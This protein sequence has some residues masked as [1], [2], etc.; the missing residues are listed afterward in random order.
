MKRAGIFLLFISL[1]TVAFGQKPLTSREIDS[2][3]LQTLKTFDVPGIAVAI[4]KDGKVTHEKGYGVRSIKT[5]EPVNEHTLFGIASN[6]K[7]FT[8][9]AL[10]MLVD[11]G[12]LQWTDRVIDFIPGFK[13]YNPYVTMNFTIADLLTHRSGLGLGA[14]DLMIWP[15]SNSFTKTEI[16]HNMRFLKPVS[17]FRTKYDYDNLLYLVAG[18][19][20]AKISGISWEEFIE[21]RIMKPLQMNESAASINR[22][23]NKT[24]VI[25]PHAPVDG[26]LKVLD[27]NWSETA[28]AAGGIYSSVHDMS[29]WVLMQLNHGNLDNGKHLFSEERQKEMWSPHTIIPVSAKNTYHTHFA[30]YG[31]GWRLNDEMGFKTVSHTGGLAG[32]VTQVMLVP[33]LDLGII[34]FTNQQSGAAFTALTNAIKDAYYGLPRT[35]R[36]KEYHDRVME[37]SSHAKNITDKVWQQVEQAEKSKLPGIDLKEYVGTY[38]DPWF[39]DIVI[40]KRGDHLYFASKKSPRLRGT[41]YFYKGNTFV[42]KWEDR[43]MDAD[44]FVLFRQNFEGQPVGIRMKPISPATDFSFDFQ[45]LD[46]ERKK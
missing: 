16:I 27:I 8:A 43:A 40:D 30:A 6:S 31:F 46:F 39:G 24:N 20:V 37:A 15:D 13:L 25:D 41:M 9:A 17:D 26:K 23:E 36:I 18:E 34:V 11:E 7:A 14:G 5:M 3:A 32:I 38:I 28:N 33:E 35:D 19:V 22:V 29:K 2:L 44:A 42:A 1:M 45:D 10:A 4:V 12:K 21:G